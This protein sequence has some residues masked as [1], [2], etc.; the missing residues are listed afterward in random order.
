MSPAMPRRDITGS[1]AVPATW[2][3]GGA[4]ERRRRIT[5]LTPVLDDWACFASLVGDISAQYAGSNMEICICA[6]DDGSVA[7]FD[8]A[9]ASLLP[10]DGCVVGTEIPR[11]DIE[12]LRLALNLGHQRA[13]AVGLC[14]L[15][16]RDDVDAVVVMDSDGEDRPIDIATLLRASTEH[17]GH[18]ILARRD[19]RS[20]SRAFRLWY[21]L[22]K[23]MFHVLTGESLNFGN[24]S[25]LPVAAVRRLV[26]MPE[27]WNNLAASIIRSRLR[28]TA[29]STSRGSRYHGRSRMNLVALIVHGLSALSVHIDTI[30]VR[31][32]LATVVVAIASVIGITAVVLIR[33]TTDLGV[34]GWATT[35]AGDLLIIL[36]Q[37]VVIVVATTLMML[38][39]RSS[40]PIIPIVDSPQYVV[41]RERYPP[42][43]MLIEAS[44]PREGP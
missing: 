23:L 9:V 13:I 34:P 11:I 21:L 12:I 26:R 7:S 15:A 39:G 30:F 31:V 8:P 36:L 3:G 18:V 4:C 19:Q 6:V 20:E 14:A 2:S 40:R 29:V 32:M 25:L 27:L 35:A 28:C 16:D 5:V 22:Y 17:P 41:H 33:F 37:T 38:A 43:A 10:P 44:S 24:F 42:S 1:A